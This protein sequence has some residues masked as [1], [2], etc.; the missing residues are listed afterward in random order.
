MRGCTGA[1]TGEQNVTGTQY[2][3]EK[4]LSLGKEYIYFYFKLKE[5]MFT[6]K[7]L[8]EALKQKRLLERFVDVMHLKKNRTKHGY[9]EFHT[10]KEFKERITTHLQKEVE[11]ISG[12]RVTA[13]KEKVSSYIFIFFVVVVVAGYVMIPSTS[14]YIQ[15]PKVPKN[16]IDSQS[17]RR[18]FYVSKRDNL[19]PG[20]HFLLLQALKDKKVVKSKNMA[21]FEVQ[22]SSQSQEKPYSVASTEMVQSLC[23][24]GYS[25]TDLA[26]HTVVDTYQ[27]HTDVIDFDADR[28]K[29]R[30]LE[31]AYKG[32]SEKLM[33]ILKGL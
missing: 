12:K 5:P 10:V 24:I 4:V 23:K 17:I 27:Y 11:R 25:I 6:S 1:I 31:D 9:K 33:K 28:A 14:K 15:K 2:E 13:K 29:E 18:G 22:F 30:C 21:A 32:V 20:T 3:I 7:E 26:K 19:T 8:D 16:S